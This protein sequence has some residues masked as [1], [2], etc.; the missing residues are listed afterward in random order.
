LGGVFVTNNNGANWT[1]ASNGLSAS[2]IMTFLVDGTNLYAGTR[3]GGIFYSTNGTSW[4]SL[5]IG[6]RSLNISSLY[7][8]GDTL[9]AGTEDRGVWTRSKINSYV[10]PGDV[11]ADMLVDNTDLL[12]I[13]LYYGQSGFSRTI[14]GNA[15]QPDTV[16][17][18]QVS[19]VNGADLSNVDCNGD[20]IINSGDTLAIALNFSM[21]HSMVASSNI[22][23]EREMIPA[24]YFVTSGSSYNAGDWVD[25]E[26]WLGTAT[27]TVTNLYGISFNI[28]YDASLVE[29]GTESLLF[30][31]SWLGT[32]GVNAITISKNNSLAN[33]EY[34]GVTRIN[35][36][37]VSGFGK[38]A[39]FKFQVSN[40][41][42][43]NTTFQLSFSSYKAVNSLGGSKVFT[44]L[45]DTLFFN[46][47][48]TNVFDPSTSSEM[49]VFPNPFSTETQITFKNEQNHSEI[50]IMDILGNVVSNVVF[51][52]KQYLLER[53]Q[54]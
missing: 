9:Y 22:E 31:S 19:Q 5:N 33:A 27:A 48:S 11:N 12:P 37:N 53:G 21:T 46:G 8:K 54:L 44:K 38:I 23:I 13:G 17:N 29:P 1:N 34:G 47:I 18:W 6:L 26:V 7:I 49:N 24:L 51:S 41:L 52:G 30:P 3:K 14:Q 15:W 28:N 20:G 39:N 16:T 2:A 36:N 10:W 25:A 32:S 50:K 4:S 42:P 35:H 43:N 45:T 40:T